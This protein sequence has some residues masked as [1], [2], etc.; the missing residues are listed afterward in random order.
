MLENIFE[1]L[2]TSDRK[3]AKLVCKQWLEVL[4]QKRFTQNEA[5]FLPH[6]YDY[7]TIMKGVDKCCRDEP[8]NLRFDRHHFY[9]KSQILWQKCGNKIASLNFNRCSFYPDMLRHIITYCDNLKHLRIEKCEIFSHPKSRLV[10]KL[11]FPTEC[12]YRRLIHKNLTSL[13]VYE[14]LSLNLSNLMFIASVF[15]QLETL[16]IFLDCSSNAKTDKFS[17]AVE[18]LQRRFHQLTSLCVKFEFG[19]DKES[20]FPKDFSRLSPANF[21]R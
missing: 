11:S 7:Q 2:P 1:F 18:I 4:S 15:P 10:Q 17:A 13:D 5:F 16:K 21:N 8:M 12:P 19:N 14:G 9:K 20:Y 6:F 3:N